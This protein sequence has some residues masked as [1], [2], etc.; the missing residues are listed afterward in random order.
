[1]RLTT[2]SLLSSILLLVAPALSQPLH[3]P[4]NPEPEQVLEIET[5]HAVEDCANQRRSK[6]GD[7]IRMHYVGTL[8]K[9]GKEFDSSYK[10]AG[11]ARKFVLG[12][13]KVIKGYI[14]PPL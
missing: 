9:N 5:L 7:T 11:G 10:K 14:S 8:Q 2:I 1:M 6:V 12:K 4:G 13:G 3:N